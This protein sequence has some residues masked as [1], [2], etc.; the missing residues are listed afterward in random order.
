MENQETLLQ[1]A[2]ILKDISSHILQM[3][4]IEFREKQL[5]NKFLLSTKKVAEMLGNIDVKKVVKMYRNKVLKG[6]EDGKNI[7]IYY[8]SIAE[9]IEKTKSFKQ[10]EYFSNVQNIMKTANKPVMVKEVEKIGRRWNK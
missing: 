5:N 1:L 2:A 7:K 3:K 4:Q 8:D 10:D 9:Y 6:I